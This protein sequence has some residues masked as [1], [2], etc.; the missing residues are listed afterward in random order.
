MTT[1]D[2]T[3]DPTPALLSAAR[4]AD[5]R[6]ILAT[7]EDAPAGILADDAAHDC[8]RMLGPVLRH[9]DALTPHAPVDGEALP[10]L[11]PQHTPTADRFDGE[12]WRGR[13]KVDDDWAHVAVRAADG[14]T[15]PMF[16][17]HG[18]WRLV[19]EVF[20]YEV[21]AAW[22][23]AQRAAGR[24]EGEA[25]R[26]AL[27]A[28][29]NE[30]PGLTAALDETRF[31]LAVALGK[32]PEKTRAFVEIDRLHADLFKR[33]ATIARLT[34]ELV[35]ARAA[36]GEAIER[37]ESL[38]IHLANAREL[39]GVAKVA[40]R[41]DGARE[42]GVQLEAWREWKEALG[43]AHRVPRCNDGEREEK[44]AEERE[45]WEALCAVDPRARATEGRQGS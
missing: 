26:A 4:L 43:R 36:H 17:W 9:L 22:A 15:A 34:A 45:A 3:P 31:E 19:A 32:E 5:A 8:A 1:D 20:G 38:E 37:N 35:A 25:E 41:L 14:A 16:Y 44:D 29:A 10:A 13:V 42:A 30:I 24:S 6:L 18:K 11:E 33:D 7:Y 23:L 27:M 40:A 2:K 39:I 21:M 12:V 28:R